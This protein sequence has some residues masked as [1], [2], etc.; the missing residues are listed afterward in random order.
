MAKAK[1]Y[2]RWAI[3]GEVGLY[4][5]QFLTRKAAIE[6]HLKARYDIDSTWGR[7]LSTTHLEFW[8]K[9]QAKGDR[10]VKVR[11]IV[12]ARPGHGGHAA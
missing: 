4:V 6:D 9:C 5:G 3:D 1:E 8:H 2:V 11:I 12:P 10:A 7:G